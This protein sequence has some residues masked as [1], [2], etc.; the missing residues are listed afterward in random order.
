MKR[1][2]ILRSTERH[3]DAYGLRPDP[4]RAAKLEEQRRAARERLGTKWIAHYSIVVGKPRAGA[5][6]KR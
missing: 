6:G 1:M 5:E 4:E 3:V 2:P